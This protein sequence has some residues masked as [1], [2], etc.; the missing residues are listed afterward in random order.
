MAISNAW[1]GPDAVAKMQPFAM[2]L[3]RKTPLLV[4]EPKGVC[5]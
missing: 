3:L 2:I 4:V 5:V 1:R